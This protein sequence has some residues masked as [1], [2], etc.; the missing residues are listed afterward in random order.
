MH[1]VGSYSSS[2]EDAAEIRLEPYALT[3]FIAV[4][5]A[6]ALS[7]AELQQLGTYD[8]AWSNPTPELN[9]EARTAFAGRGRDIVDH[10]LRHNDPRPRN[11]A[12]F[13]VLSALGDVEATL[14]LIEALPD[15][16]RVESGILDRFEGEITSLIEAILEKSAVGA[17]ERVV[18][19]L[20]AAVDRSR[21][22]PGREPVVTQVIEL[23]GR[24]QGPA[25]LAALERFAGDGDPKVR[26]TAAESLGR[27]DAGKK[28]EDQAA[29]IGNLARMLDSD[30]NAEARRQAAESLGRLGLGDAID[31]LRRA[32]D[33]DQDSRT[34]DA[35]VFSLEHL[36][37]PVTDPASCRRIAE[38]C[39]EAEAARPLFERWKPTADRQAL[40]DAATS[41]APA[42]RALALEE[43]L[44]LGR[45]A[46]RSR[47]AL[48]SEPP[49]PQPLRQNDVTTG[50][51]RVAPARPQ[52]P[53]A[54]AP[55]PPLEPEILLS[56]RESSLDLLGRK[57]SLSS[58]QIA[59]N[60]LWALAGEK[61]S[62]ALPWTDRISERNARYWASSFLAYRDR[63]GYDTYRRLREGLAAV[64]SAALFLLILVVAPQ[65][66]AAATVG[67]AS[68]LGWGV[69]AFSVDGPLSLPP[70]PL[71]LSTVRFLV[72]VSVGMGSAA[73]IYLNRLRPLAGALGAG[74]MFFAL[75]ILTRE[76]GF[77]VPDAQE[78]WAFLF[79]PIIGLATA[80]ILALGLTLAASRLRP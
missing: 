20:L 22:R 37:A 10:F 52:L 58:Y 70:W 69:S 61:I 60:T 24:C 78:G 64:V 40:L 21:R 13:F 28:K 36:G 33:R 38:R 46:V 32:L 48:V 25:A 7:S 44:G 49:V 2:F 35:I 19:A 53:A 30:P 80:P 74:A 79:D 51:A 56:L 57:I 34:I 11:D 55:P 62:T 42:L 16:P 17:D 75:Y 45:G 27:L 65:W 63:A 5:F 77:F 26:A 23:I 6:A 73:A 54:P 1:V 31:P 41:A 72:G 39:W 4:A 59:A 50:G 9:A 3:P 68:A 67:L 8:G 76:I 14:A 66:R 15:P 47:V 71:P 18:P 29:A 12:Y 43:I